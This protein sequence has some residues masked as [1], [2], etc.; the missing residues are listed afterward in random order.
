MCISHK[1]CKIFAAFFVSGD[2]PPDLMTESFLSDDDADL[3]SSSHSAEEDSQNVYQKT[4]TYINLIESLKDAPDQLQQK[5]DKLE[6]LKKELQQSI[7]DLK[8]QS[9][10]ALD[11]SSSN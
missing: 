6:K 8:E 10:N 4:L 3:P 11:K 2:N 9:Q 1:K 5:S 7:D